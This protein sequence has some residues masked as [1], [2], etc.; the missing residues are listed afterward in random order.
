MDT[1]LNNLNELP[2]PHIREVRSFMEAK[3][4]LSFDI[5]DGKASSQ[6]YGDKKC[7][8]G[9]CCCSNKRFKKQF[10]SLALPVSFVSPMVIGMIY[11]TVWL[12]SLGSA[13]NQ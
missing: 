4:N 7:C 1:I 9:C 13:P 5:I 2:I 6:L 10:K 8:Y 11:L 3:V 12:C